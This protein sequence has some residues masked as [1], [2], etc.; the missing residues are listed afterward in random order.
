MSIIIADGLE[1]G[2]GA[3]AFDESGTRSYDT[4]TVKTGTYSLR[5]NPTTTATGYVRYRGVAATGIVTGLGLAAC[6]AAFKFR[7]AT[8]PSADDEPIFQFLSPGA[9]VKLEV[10]LDSSRNLVVYDKDGSSVATGS[11]VLA[12]NTWY[13]IG[14]RGSNGTTGAYAVEIDG[15]SELSG[16]CN[17]QGN[18]VDYAVVGKFTDRNGETIDVF[19]DDIVIDDTAFP[20]S[21]WEIGEIL[22]N[23]DGSTQEFANG[24]GA[25]DYTQVDEL[26]PSNSDY[27]ASTGSAGDQAL[28]DMESASTG[29][30]SGTILAL[31]ACIRGR[32]PSGT[33]SAS[34]R[35]RSNTTNSDSTAA[36]LG[37]TET[38][39]IRVLANDPDTAA[40]WLTGG[41]DAVEVGI[42]E[43]NA[44][45]TR[46]SFVNAQVVYV[47]SGGG[48][49]IL[50]QMM[51]HYY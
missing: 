39:R 1:T 7:I 15:S 51:R 19:Y 47:P 13:E 36:A 44:V 8:A 6:F 31:V 26:P 14:V 40:A 25:S 30:I 11:T 48:G 17:Q 20:T 5:V 23:A 41:I 9:T 4:G 45:T 28:F 22:P 27:V 42:I 35:V 32:T 49:T 37:G 33:S 46:L 3:L 21:G 24:T 43:N 10:R 18:N 29:G 50:P 12:L 38:T 2:S 16:T 34:L